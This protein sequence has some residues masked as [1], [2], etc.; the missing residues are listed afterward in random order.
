[1][2]NTHSLRWALRV[3]IGI[4]LLALLPQVA[5]AQNCNTVAASQVFNNQQFF[6]VTFTNNG[7]TTCSV[8]VAT[9]KVFH[10]FTTAPTDAQL[11]QQTLF[12]FQTATL[13]PGQRVTLQAMRPSCNFQEDAF[14]GDL[15]PVFKSSDYYR[16]RVLIGYI[17]FGRGTCGSGC[18]LTPG[19]W[20]N[21]AGDASNSNGNQEDAVT[22][23]LPIWLGDPN[24]ANSV[25][26]TNATQ[27]VALLSYSY[28]GG[29]ADNP[30]SKLYRNLLAAKLN[31][32]NGANGSLIATAIV[33]ADAFL[34]TH[35]QNSPLTPQERQMVLSWA[36]LFDN[37]NN[38]QVAGGPSH[39]N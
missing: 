25:L 23:L 12:D 28:N 33:A 37:F 30:V 10:Q 21:H 7:G 11:N 35:D 13:Q 24:G 16:N 14:T 20:K 15:V 31:L 9:Y 39:C 1:M 38:G 4:A 18:T 5:T 36:T 34:S 26:V 8:G 6:T 29:S 22:P 27:A 32:R 3:C 19:Y 2:S 17:Y